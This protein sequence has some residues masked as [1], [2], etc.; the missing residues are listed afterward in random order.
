MPYS[1]PT[2]PIQ[3]DVYDGP[4]GSHAVRI[5]GLS[6]NLAMGKRVYANNVLAD[7]TVIGTP[8]AFGLSPVL[9]VPALSDLRSHMQGVPPDLVQ[10]PA[11]S[12]RWYEVRD[13]EDVGKG[14]PN[15]YRAALLA[16]AYEVPGVQDPIY[17]G[18]FWPIPMP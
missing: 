17:E 16:K 9:L 13:V 15:E 2:F 12:G 8:Y 18:L 14:F 11:G 6:C 3:C 5:S 10:V 4:W 7:F 1:I